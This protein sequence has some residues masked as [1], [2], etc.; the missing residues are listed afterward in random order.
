MNNLRKFNLLMGFFHLLQGLIMLY[1]SNDFGIKIYTN[2]LSAQAGIPFP[3]PSWQ[4]VMTLT[5]GPAV[6]SFLFLSAIAHFLL[7]SPGIFQWYKYNLGRE[8]NFARWFEYALSSS[9]MLV[10]IA[11]L[12]GMYDLGSLILLFGLN[13][14]MNLFGLLMEQQNSRLKE[15]SELS[16]TK[17]RPDWK[18]FIFGC[19]A[20]II[21]WIVLAMY[22]FSA[23]ANANQTTKVPDFVYAIFY[24]LFI[25]FNIFAIN[26]YL[27]YKQYGPW[28]NYLFG[29]KVYIVLSLV[30]KS[31]LAWQVFGGTLR[32]Q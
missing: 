5:I 27:Q 28:K 6:A 16:K 4:E 22:F 26:M 14:C 3:V 24:S 1:L 12:C 2:Y 30:A 7:V 13:A 9:V 18:A 21:P 8:V 29:E 15:L 32:P 11:L 25:F 17:Y 19:I 23:L 31:L 10:I 20:G